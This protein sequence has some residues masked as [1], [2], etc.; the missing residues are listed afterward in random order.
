MYSICKRSS[1]TKTL[2][3]WGLTR[4]ERSAQFV[5]HGLDAHKIQS[6]TETNFQTFS[7]LALQKS[8]V[9]D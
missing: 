2:L 1:D 8:T 4:C 3:V 7:S 6:V 9:I 5:S